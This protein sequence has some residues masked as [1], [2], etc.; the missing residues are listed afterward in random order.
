MAAFLA[1]RA[2]LSFW[3][4]M[5]PGFA[6]LIWGLSRFGS[7]AGLWLYAVF[8]VW[9]VA[10]F[11]FINRQTWRLCRP[12][13][14]TLDHRCDPEPLLEVCR[15]VLRQNPNSLYF[16]V[17]EGHALNLLGREED[18]LRSAAQAEGSP[19]LWRD[20][21]LLLVW[22]ASLPMGDPRQERALETLERL[23][24]RL[25]PQ[26]Q[27]LLEQI[28][29]DRRTL[30]R[31]EADD[32]ALEE[33]LTARLARADC[34]RTRVGAHLALGAYYVHRKDLAAEAHL[35]FVL[36]NANKLQGARYQAERMLCLLPKP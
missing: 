21:H 31:L 1:A 17:Y 22:S 36:D 4:A 30:N 3:C 19:R 34:L 20:P 28:L 26:G 35:H 25:P 10:A 5:V 8:V 18:A 33:L 29:S 13:L 27:A 14:D 23:R 6:F 12:A 7:G 16:R 9:A 2:R 15:M 11:V 24:R 32:P